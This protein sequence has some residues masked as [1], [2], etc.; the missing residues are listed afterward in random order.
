MVTKGGE[1]HNNTAKL[2][3]EWHVSG[4]D[5]EISF[6]EWLQGRENGKIQG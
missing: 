3:K 5:R 4:A 1:E 2:I 6:V